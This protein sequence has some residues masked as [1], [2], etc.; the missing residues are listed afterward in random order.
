MQQIPMGLIGNKIDEA[1]RRRVASEERMNLIHG[2]SSVL[3]EYIS[4]P[5]E[6]PP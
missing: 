1:E 6:I 2:L 5:T 4:W 3:S